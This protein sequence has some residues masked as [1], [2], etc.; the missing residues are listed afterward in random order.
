MMYKENKDHNSEIDELKKFLPGRQSN[1]IA[2][3]HRP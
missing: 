1:L 3:N 2:G